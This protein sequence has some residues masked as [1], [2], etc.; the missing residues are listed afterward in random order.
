MYVGY[1]VCNLCLYAVYSSVGRV[2]VP[3]KYFLRR[4]LNS[5]LENYVTGKDNAMYA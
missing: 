3:K 5:D 4:K 1:P 2:H